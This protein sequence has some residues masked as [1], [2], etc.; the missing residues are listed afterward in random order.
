MTATSETSYKFGHLAHVFGVASAGA[1]E[2]GMPASPPAGLQ[3]PEFSGLAARFPHM[4]RYSS[5]TVF[6]LPAA[7]ERPA[8]VSVSANLWLTSR[9]PTSSA[10]IART[11][12]RSRASGA[13]FQ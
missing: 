6:P 11:T 1:G 5:S 7:S 4:A 2:A 9:W 10:R 8:P 3:C 12:S 13:S